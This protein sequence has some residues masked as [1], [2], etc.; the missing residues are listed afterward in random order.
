MN[1]L[2]AVFLGIVQGLTEFLPVSSSGHLVLVQHFFEKIQNKQ[3]QN[4]L[5]FDTILHCGTLVAVFIALRREIWDILRRPFQR[6][7][8][9]LVLATGVTVSIA[10][11]FKDTVEKAFESGL[12][13]GPAFLITAAALFLSEYLSR[14]P[15][16]SRNDAEMSWLD[17][18]FIGALQG[19]AIIPGISRSGFT[20]AGALS[21]RLERDLAARFSFLLSIPAILGALVLQLK[22]L[23]EISGFESINP[24][25]SGNL[26]GGIGIPAIVAGTLTSAIVGFAAVTLALRLIRKRSLVVF[27]IYT[28][29]LG[30][31]VLLDQNVM[32]IVF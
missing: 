17:A 12:W 14:R 5:F 23:H 16:N 26:V 10:L 32:H 22:E 7:T 4:P 27:G 28:A 21:C 19:I 13:L 30:V 24:D 1:I 8:I 11:A 2:E 6:I 15:G 20:I 9:L 3:W 25:I 29:L 18:F 31:L